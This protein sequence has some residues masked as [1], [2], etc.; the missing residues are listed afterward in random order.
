M[1][2]VIGDVEIESDQV[3]A[4]Y[5]AKS[6]RIEH[7]HRVIT[8]KGGTNPKRSEIEARAMELA[9]QK[10]KKTLHL[11]TVLVSPEQFRPGRVHTVDLKTGSIISEQLKPQK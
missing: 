7:L 10:G 5:D 8:V 1:S 3:C 2:Q 9:R 4:V 11:K 6:G